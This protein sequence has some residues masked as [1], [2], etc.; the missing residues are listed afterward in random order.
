MRD[1]KLEMG[2]GGV[3]EFASIFSDIFL[4]SRR[5]ISDYNWKVF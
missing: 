2:R 1:K 5:K 3:P 4:L